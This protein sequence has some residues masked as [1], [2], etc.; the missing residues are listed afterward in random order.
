MIYDRINALL[1]YTHLPPIRPAAMQLD[2][3]PL[4]AEDGGPFGYRSNTPVHDLLDAID[5]H[6]GIITKFRPLARGD[7]EL[8]PVGERVRRLERHIQMHEAPPYFWLGAE[9]PSAN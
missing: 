6:V 3:R 2:N 8:V 7:C 4:T 9:A 1:V 5:K